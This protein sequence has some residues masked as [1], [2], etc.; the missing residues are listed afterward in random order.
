MEI[1]TYERE[2]LYKEVWAEPMTTVAKRYGISDVA[3]RKHCKKLEIPLPQNGH[4]AKVKARHNIK[5]PPLPK[6]KGPD[7]IVVTD[8]KTNNESGSVG[9]KMSDTLL[10]LQEDQR[11]AV[12]AYCSS[13]IVPSEL[14]HP[15]GLIKDT[16]Q[17]IRS[18]KESTRPPLNRVLNLGVSEEQK[19]RVYRIFSTIFKAFEHL[20]YSVVIKTPRAER[21]YNYTPRVYDNET[22]I[23][24]GQDGVPICVKEKQQ[25]V[26]H[27]PTKEE[28]EEKRTSSYIH[29]PP[30]DLVKTGKLNFE[31]NEYHSKRKNWRDS[32]NR[33]IEDQI[34]E[35][36]IWV[37]EA[38]HVVKMM[39]E[40]REAEKTRRLE[41]ETRQQ[42]L[43]EKSK[44]ELE[45]VEL[46]EELVS[47][48]ERAEKI[49]RFTDSVE[50]K[51]TKITDEKYKEELLNWLIWAR[52]KADWL[53]PLSEKEDD[54]LGK[55]QHLFDFIDYHH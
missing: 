12:K 45:E 42:Q 33:K 22:Y 20:G 49:R 13:V 44:H 35:I 11:L 18:R 39:Q 43:A 47:D 53:D 25:R 5:V 24:L 32:D 21:Y 1:R 2:K 28:L 26:D 29:I 54:I 48:W 8:W 19:E 6:S 38:I 17:Y 23:C 31:I 51:S 7:K 41:E 46:L 4:W 30:Y 36:I 14:T 16:I 40:K 34:G 10:F 55:R 3:L 27:K 15:H 37:M 52:N 50:L 9:A